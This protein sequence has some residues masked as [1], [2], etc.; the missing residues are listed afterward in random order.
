MPNGTPQTLPP[1]FF[2]KKQWSAPPQT[3]PSDF[4][5]K[6]KTESTK[7]EPTETIS[8]QPSVLE[9]IKAGAKSVAM[10]PFNLPSAIGSMT[11]GIENYTQEGRK[12]HPVLSRV[13]D[14][15]KAGKDYADLL[16]T[17]LSITGGEGIAGD[18][19]AAKLAS[20]VEPS[21]KV[22][23]ILGVTAKE[24]LPG[25]MP[26]SLDEFAVNPGRGV[27]KAG[28]DESKLAKMDALERN[29]SIMKAK[30]AAGKK[31]AQALDAAGQQGKTVDAYSTI[32]K[33][34]AKLD[35]SEIAKAEKMLNEI[36]QNHG[37]DIGNLE[38]LTPAQAHAVKQALWEDGSEAADL[39]RRGIAQGIKDAVP[40]AKDALRD[41]ADLSGA[42][43]AAQ[44]GAQKFAK[45]AP[46]SALRKMI[47]K[48][49]LPKA[50][51]G[52]GITGGG[53]A[54]YELYRSL[55]GGK[56]SSPTP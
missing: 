54:M 27:V 41:Y 18:V 34:F 31:L 32:T 37:I 14:V 6:T 44:R 25:K 8:A 5:S 10:D 43:K 11:S 36:F 4:F 33:V 49:V 48:Q 42:A 56:G 50:A 15:T 28:L 9:K 51:E 29:Q 7:T 26:M 1:D 39:I 22:N 3:L 45:E 38:K 12:E 46:Q 30:D 20:K 53:L 21:Q 35:A 2:S 19:A 23:K 47:M 52:A 16:A 17:T 13:G 55:F 24:I 40:E